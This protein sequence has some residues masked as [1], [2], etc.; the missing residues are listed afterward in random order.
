M[1]AKYPWDACS[2]K[3]WYIRT[4]LLEESVSCQKWLVSILGKGKIDIHLF[5]ALQTDDGIHHSIFSRVNRID[6]VFSLNFCTVQQ[7]EYI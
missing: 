6:E 7:Q 4:F 3:S 1:L 5:L 2:F